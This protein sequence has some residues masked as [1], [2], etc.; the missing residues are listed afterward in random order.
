MPHHSLGIDIG[1]TFTDIVVY[2]HDSGRQWS[3]KVLTTHEDPARAVAAGVAALLGEGRLAPEHFTRV[4]HATTLFTNALIE[5]KGARHRPHHDGGLRRH[6][7]DR[8]RAQV[9]AV[10]PPDRQARA[11]CP[12]QP[13]PRGGRALARGRRHRAPPRHGA[14]R[15]PRPGA[16]PGRGRVH[17]GGLPPRLRQSAPRG[18]GR[19]PHRE[20]PSEDRGHDVPRGRAR[21]PRVRA[22]LDDGRQRVHQAAR[23]PLPRADGEAARR[24]RH[25]GS[26]PPHAVERR[27]D[28]RGRGPADAGADA[29]V[30]PRGRRARRRLL[31]PRRR[32][33]QA[34]RLRHGRHHRQALARGRRRAADGLQ[35]RGGAPEALHGRQRPAHPHLDD[36]AD[37]DRRGRRQHRL[38]GRDR[39]PQGRAAERGLPAGSRLLR[40]RR[41]RAHGDR[42]GFPPR[43]PQP[44][45]LRRR[46]GQGGCRG[47]AAGDREAGRHAGARA[48][49]GRV[50]HPRHRQREHGLRR[51]RAH[52]RAR[53]GPSRLRA[54]LH[55]RRGAR[56]RPRG[57]AEARDLPGDLP[58]V[59]RRRV[60]AGP[61]RR[62]GARRPRGDGRGP[63]RHGQHRVARGGVQAPRRRGAG[64]HGRHRSQARDGDREAPGGRPL[65]GPGLRPRRR[66]ARRAL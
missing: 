56:P 5:R 53:A 60:G 26:A 42:R 13:A 16:R 65:P 2:D 66:A 32:R 4:V 40:S 27:A 29:R 63:S 57:R 28:P 1:G 35:L 52:R 49:Q 38:R 30:R 43:L 10:R 15:E 3:R 23:P 64:G 51:A 21:D 39:A 25:P 33:R 18:A 31:R 47:G 62:A 54:P 20:A 59:G 37:R 24:P 36:R 9:R 22:R 11:P 44:R 17:R 61:S 6:A 41:D 46:R 48:D 12:A 7:R 45:L 19:A 8:P 55:R 34:P 58:A 50:G 14:A